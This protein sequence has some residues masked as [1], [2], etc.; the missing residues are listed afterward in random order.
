MSEHQDHSSAALIAGARTGRPSEWVA[1]LLLALVLTWG[2]LIAIAALAFGM[3]I[4]SA[5]PGDIGLIAAAGVAIVGLGLGLAVGCRLAVPL[6]QYGFGDAPATFGLPSRSRRLQMAGPVAGMVVV[7]A[8]A[9]WALSAVL[10]FRFG[11]LSCLYYC[12][13][14]VLLACLAAPR[15][16]G[17]LLIFGVILVTGVA[18][19]LPVRA[20]QNGIA[21]QL[22][23]SDSGVSVRAQAQVVVL[24]GLVQ[25]PYTIDSGT[26]IAQ[27]DTVE[28]GLSQWAAVE[29]VTAK[30][31]DPC[32]PV[33][34]AEGDADGTESLSCTQVSPGLWL[35]GSQLEQGIG[36]VLERDGVTITVTAGMNLDTNALRQAVLAAHP[37][38]DAELWPR[39]DSTRYSLM[40]LLLL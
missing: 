1:G 37:A 23:L 32:A 19:A 15:S 22:W 6:L 14:G 39:E 20:L 9:M 7:D 18:L 17:R 10:P 8:A 4:D 21:A 29:T 40:G 30:K 28:D 31:T 16:K 12:L 35:R 26:L 5:F 25:E 24:P 2:A 38:S 3:S 27:F 33:L 36:Y 13:P 11:L 34:V